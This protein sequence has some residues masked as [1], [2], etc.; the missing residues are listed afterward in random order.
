MERSY[1]IKPNQMVNL[2][3]FEAPTKLKDGLRKTIKWF[4]ENKEKNI[5]KN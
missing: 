2:V 3:G 1:G 5:I 4:I